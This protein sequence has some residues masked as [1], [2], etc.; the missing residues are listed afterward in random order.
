MFQRK[1]LIF[2]TVLLLLAFA[3]TSGWFWMAD[4]LRSDIDAFVETQKS[5]GVTLSWENLRVSGFPIRFDTDFT[6]PQARLDSVD[7]TITWTG[8]S[9]SIRPFIEGPGVVSFRAPGTHNLEIREPGLEL[10]IESQSDSLNGHL[11]FGKTGQVQALRG[12][13]EPF[14]LQF[15]GRERIGI[16]RAAFDFERLPMTGSH[17]SIHPD[18][19]ADTLAVIL[20]RID[21]SD[22]PIDDAVVKSLGTELSRVAA[23]MSLRGPLETESISPETLARWRDAGGTVE[24][25]SLELIWGPLGFA[26]EGTLAVDNALQP[27]GAFSARIS[28][29]DKLIDLLEQ[30]GQIRKQQAA[31][32]R[33]AM[34]VLT[35][36]PANGGPPE[37][38]V[39]VTIQDR[40][41]SIGPI[42]LFQLD[43]IVWN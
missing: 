24:I 37:A 16:A 23:E 21:L 3:W 40:V 29:L 10:S 42:S 14:D 28:G 7:R 41:V 35:R 25:E 6:A 9:T 34:A 30:R 20:D 13:A 31:I 1:Y 36:T 15:N 22:L 8:P 12:L 2:L 38:R 4:R 39:P 5:N 33:I 43:P 27:V 32:A 19:V 17:D 11:G 26:G 18:P